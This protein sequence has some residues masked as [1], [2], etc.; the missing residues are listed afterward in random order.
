MSPRAYL[1][2]C[3]AAVGFALGYAL[4]VYAHL[5]NLYYDPIARQLLVGA[6][7]GPVPM[8]Y[9]GQILYG[10]GAAL[11]AVGIIRVVVRRAPSATVI[12]LAG[13]WA[14]TAIVLVGAYFTWNNWP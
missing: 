8:G 3:A 2:A 1:A 9:L 4:P 6:W 14:L 13:A 7:P 5:Q 12:A 11:I 10:L